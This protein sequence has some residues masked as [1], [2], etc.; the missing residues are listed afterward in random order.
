MN[1]RPIWITK[2]EEVLE[3]YYARPRQSSNENQGREVLRELIG[4][5]REQAKQGKA[6]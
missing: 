4:R 3:A 5:M 2:Q 6:K 1:G